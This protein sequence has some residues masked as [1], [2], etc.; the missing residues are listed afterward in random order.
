[1]AGRAAAE[2]G[3]VTLD[4]HRLR[5]YQGFIAGWAD[6]SPPGKP[7][8]SVG[9][10]CEGDLVIRDHSERHELLSIPAG[11]WKPEHLATLIEL[12]DLYN[13][14]RGSRPDRRVTS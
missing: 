3:I 12:V 7:A 11:Q 13:A 5:S 6:P 1:M 4:E 8:L 2:E 14:V 9:P 10:T